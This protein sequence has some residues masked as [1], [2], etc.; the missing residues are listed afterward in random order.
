MSLM[1]NV[2][3]SG[4]SALPSPAAHQTLRSS[5]YLVVSRQSGFSV[6]VLA[7]ATDV[8]VVVEVFALGPQ[9]NEAEMSGRAQ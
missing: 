2:D 9:W 8:G 5:T 3:L 6:L 7:D 1:P 4:V